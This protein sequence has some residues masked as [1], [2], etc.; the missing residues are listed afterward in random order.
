MLRRD[1]VP[2]QQ[3]HLVAVG[4]Q[5]APGPATGGGGDAGREI[6]FRFYLFCGIAHGRM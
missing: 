6:L 2:G 4:H 1:P 5:A 3:L